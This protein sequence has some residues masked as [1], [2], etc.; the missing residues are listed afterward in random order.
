[1][2]YGE[3]NGDARKGWFLSLQRFGETEVDGLNDGRGPQSTGTLYL[4][5]PRDD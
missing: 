5:V 1:M 2:P 4:C 3:P